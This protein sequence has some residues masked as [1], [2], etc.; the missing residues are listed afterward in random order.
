PGPAGP[1]PA[2]SAPG[3]V[4]S[5]PGSVGL[6]PSSVGPAPGPAA[7]GDPDAVRAR[8][9]RM[10]SGF[11]LVDEDDVDLD[12]DLMDAGFDSISLTEL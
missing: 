8:L 2:G 10:A 5:A 6:A 3:S 7:L 9:R 1:G 12:D 11:L 4:G